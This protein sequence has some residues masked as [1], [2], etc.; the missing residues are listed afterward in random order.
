MKQ[1]L[2]WIILN[3]NVTVVPLDSWRLCER[4]IAEAEKRYE[5][6]YTREGRHTIYMFCTNGAQ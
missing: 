4:T 3:N 6:I 5:E 2:L 1:V